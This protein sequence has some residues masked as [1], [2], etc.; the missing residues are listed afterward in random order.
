[1]TEQEAENDLLSVLVKDYTFDSSK[2]VEQNVERL[3]VCW[4]SI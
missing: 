1:M 3:R 4:T 2:D